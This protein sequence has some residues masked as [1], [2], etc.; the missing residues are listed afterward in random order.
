MPIS[1]VAM[2]E[3]ISNR[4][5]SPGAWGNWPPEIPPIVPGNSKN[6]IADVILIVVSVLNLSSR[7]QKARKGEAWLSLG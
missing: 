7:E 1:A 4:N 3:S 6:T 2:E 5:L